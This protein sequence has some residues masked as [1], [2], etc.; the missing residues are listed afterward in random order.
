MKILKRL[1][2]LI[3]MPFM[4]ILVIIMII[5]MALATF[6]ESAQGTNAAW[7]LIYDAWWF[8][9]LFA[10]VL[11]NLV[12]NV[13][14]LKLYR[15]SKLTVFVFHIA[16]ALIIIGGGVSRYFAVE[17][18]MHIREGA[19]SGTLI[20]DDTY[21]N[22]AVSDGESKLTDTEKVRLS[23]LTP[24]KFRW[25]GELNGRKIRI[26]S[27]DY[28]KNA[29]AQYVAAP[30]GEP[31]M[32]MVMLAGRQVNVGLTS[33]EEAAYPGVSVSFNKPGSEA[34]LRVESRGENLIAVSSYPV[35]ITAMGGAEMQNFAAGEELLLEQQKLYAVNNVRFALQRFL[36]SAKMKFVDAGSSGQSTG[37]DVAKME[38]TLDGMKSELY[39]P[40]HSNLEGE[41]A[42]ITM[43]STTISCAYGSKHIRLPFVLRLQD[44]R[45]DRYPGSNSPSSFESDVELIDVEKDIKEV[46]NIY[47]NNVLKHRFYRFYQSSYDQ[48]ELGTILS[49][50]RD[51]T[52]TSITYAGYV[53]MILGMLLALVARGT[54]FSVL[55][56]ATAGKGAK[57]ALVIVAMLMAGSY[58]HAQHYPVPPKEDAAAFGKIWVQGKEGRFKPMN[59]LSNEVMRKVVNE[60][61][62]DGHTADQVMLGMIAYPDEWKQ[63]PI[64]EVDNP[65]LHQMIGFKGALVSFNDFI[66]EGRYVLSQVV[67]DAYKKRVQERTD[68]DKEVMKLDEKINVFY[69][70][71]T[72][73]LLKIFP[74]P[75]AADGS[76]HAVSDLLNED[77]T[78]TDTLGRVFLLYTRSLREGDSQMAGEILDFIQQYQVKNSLHPL[79]EGVK[80]AE[81]LYNKVGLYDKLIGFYGIFG[82][83]LLGLQFFRIFHPRKWVE[84]MFRIGV[85][86]L[87][88]GFVLHTAFLGLRW[89]VSGHAPMSNGYESMIFVSWISLLAGLVFVRRTGFALALTAILSMLSLLVAHMSWMNPDITNLVPVLKSPWLTIHVTVI[90]AGYGFLGMSMLM[91]LIN[92]VFFAILNRRNRV[93]IASVLEQ[94]T[95]V[96]H[97]SVI[98]GLYFLTIGTFLGGIWANESWGRYWGWDPKETWALIS[99]LVYT[100]VTHMHRFPGMKGTFAFNLATLLGFSSILMTYFGVNYFLGGIH[101]YAGGVAF[102]IPGWIYILVLA[103]ATLSMIAYSKQKVLTSDYLPES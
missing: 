95:K 5:S 9:L 16:F 15:R 43:G 61:H 60:S 41:P 84:Y 83:L 19:M 90:M 37:M 14:K 17:G 87:G 40:G 39:V 89:Y 57:V 97:L 10:L 24:G 68:L 94:V 34:D 32:Q 73:A 91:G 98:I 53:L 1:S 93:R 99:V 70:V 76:W 81:I 56:R 11:V 100:F 7:A 4:G 22:V 25:K 49:V 88:V 103:L 59:T 58:A 23:V 51:A 55:S 20:S 77:H 2:F 48:D 42:S 31:Y 3:G 82:F 54:R 33:G 72:G 35:V 29:V 67:N 50:K 12:G 44:F 45:I 78:V 36:P 101:S 30:G 71:Q 92:L 8:E 79:D 65:E 62:F 80:K 26:R 96:N 47:M 27:T 38:V 28:L 52:G 6:V 85:V 102:A 75:S 18:M 66:V 63:A 21:V 46:H 64:F 13:I 74:D 86:H 69:M